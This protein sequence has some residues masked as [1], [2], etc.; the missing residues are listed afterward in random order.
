MEASGLTRLLACLVE[1]RDLLHKALGH[2]VLL[3]GAALE[4]NEWEQAIRP[5]V[6]GLAVGEAGKPAEASPVCRTWIGI[7]A[8]GKR[9]R[10]EGADQLGQDRG[11]LEPGLEVTGTG[12]DD[13]ARRKPSAASFA[14]ELSERSSRAV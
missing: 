1:L 10:G 2:R 13:G 14:S 11:V 6:L 12:L 4:A 7:V 5:L 3:A 9:L 8:G